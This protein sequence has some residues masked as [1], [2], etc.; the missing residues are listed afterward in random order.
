MAGRFIRRAVPMAMLVGAAA[1]AP[2]DGV[3]AAKVNTL[4]SRTDGAVLLNGRSLAAGNV[5]RV[6]GILSERPSSIRPDPRSSGFACTVRWNGVLVVDARNFSGSDPCAPRTGYV[7]SMTTI[8]SR[9]RTDRGLRV[10]QPLARLRALY[11]NARRVGGGWQITT[12]RHASDQ[13]VIIARMR[14]GRVRAFDAFAG[15]AGP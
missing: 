12:R 1:R 15:A 7:Q 13:P 2:I 6:A 11:P 3:A 5:A 10:G 4:A 14:S 8:G 9:W